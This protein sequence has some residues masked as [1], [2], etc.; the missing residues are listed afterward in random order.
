VG[1]SVRY[2]SGSNSATALLAAFSQLTFSSYFFS[3]IS[4][5]STFCSF[6]FISFFLSSPPAATISVN[7][8]DQ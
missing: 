2:P 7:N 1:Y 5:L 6:Y 8:N 3:K 4:A